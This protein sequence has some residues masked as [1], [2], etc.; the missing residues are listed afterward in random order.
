MKTT[1][2]ELERF[3]TLGIADNVAILDLDLYLY[4]NEYDILA[5]SRNS[6]GTRNGILIRFNNSA[7]EDLAGRLFVAFGCDAFLF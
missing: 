2:R 1:K 7:P 4:C 3:E 5:I 6:V